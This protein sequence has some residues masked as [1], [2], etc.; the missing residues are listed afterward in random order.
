[1]HKVENCIKT[2]GR[3]FKC[4]FVFPNSISQR[5]TF[6]KALDI[7]GESTLPSELYLSWN[8]FIKEHIEKNENNG[9]KEVDNT[10]RHLYAQYIVA[11]NA[12]KTLFASLIPTNC[13][14]KLF[15]S[16]L[17]SI[18][19]Q[20]QPFLYKSFVDAEL[21]DLHLLA[22]SYS[23]F[24]KENNLYES[25][26]SQLQFNESKSGNEKKYIII[27][28]ELIDDFWQY[29]QVLKNAEN[30]EFLHVENSNSEDAIL[31]EAED[32]RLELKYVMSQI[33][34]LLLKKVPLSDI[35]VSVVDI[36][37]LK[38][39][40]ISEAECRG[41]PVDFY[42]QSAIN[43]DRVCS[44][45]KGI[46]D[47][48][49]THYS[50]QAI[51]KLLLKR[52]IP[53]KFESEIDAF[54]TF[55]LKHNCSISWQDAGMWKNVWEEAF[56]SL[57]TRSTEE[58]GIGKLFALLKENIDAICT[59]CTFDEMAE[60]IEKFISDCVEVSNIKD[61]SSYFFSKCKEMINTLK[62][63]EKTFNKYLDE[64]SINRYDF[65]V[66][67]LEK[68]PLHSDGSGQGI[69]IFPYGAAASIPFK[70]HFVI[71]LNQRDATIIRGKLKFLRDDKR[72]AMS[73]RDVDLTTHFI[74]SYLGTENIQFS[75][76]K[77]TY[78]KYAIAHSFFGK[79]APLELA[80]GAYQD[81]YHEGDSLYKEECFYL[82]KLSLAKVS[83]AKGGVSKVSATELLKLGKIYKLQK[84]AMERSGHFE[85]Y[86]SF[87][88]LQES[89][90]TRIPKLN[91]AI[92]SIM[93]KGGDFAISQSDL[94]DFFLE[95][96]IYFLFKKILKIEEKSLS[97]STVEDKVM[98]RLEAGTLYH[99]IMERIYRKIF[100]F[101]EGK[102]C[103]SCL[104]CGTLDVMQKDS[105]SENI[106]NNDSNGNGY[107]DIAQ[108]VLAEIK[109]DRQYSPLTRVC[110]HSMHDQFV[111]AIEDIFS[112]DAE[113]FDGYEIYLLE[114]N[115]EFASS[116]GIL[117]KGK[118]D[119]AMK[120]ND[121]II[122]LDYKTGAKTPSCKIE[123]GKLKDFQMPLY[124]L[125]L[126]N[127]VIEQKD[128]K[129][130][131]NDSSKTDSKEEQN[132]QVQI[133]SKE[134]TE[135]M[136]TKSVKS[137]FFIKLLKGMQVCVF[138]D[139]KDKKNMNRQSF[140]TEI[141]L[142][143]ETAIEMRNCVENAD[144]APSQDIWKTC[145]EC[146]FRHICRT[147][148]FVRKRIA[149]K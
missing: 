97:F 29:E 55:G 148:F 81:G 76:S 14:T 74:Q 144:F 119:R 67:L 133:D 135:L 28:P 57:G 35:A 132:L 77:K 147:T 44:I 45:F 80:S 85:N 101:S 130:D 13:N 7:S 33:E 20:V 146:D 112:L 136:E 116:D 118:I 141:D 18:L 62:G 37:A 69:S 110:M 1:M 61:E 102:F 54:L 9:F 125:L 23:A 121:S 108:K 75:Y 86:H 109:T 106:S 128:A 68:E 149:G 94:H 30:I 129:T 138:E 122:L 92:E 21:K 25:S 93:M 100:V 2:N 105:S 41:I 143:K 42:V 59:A 4:C 113:Y 38:S 88:I 71:N 124:V 43:D 47:V 89:C 64:A 22:K 145:R 39:Y 6:Q 73:M 26:W 40:I 87:S 95:C 46:Q 70:H 117:Y 120:K 98:D 72:D 137:A 131:S 58:E 48:Y 19:P 51:K 104:S 91:H 140:E 114:G 115:L 11:C 78:K 27:Y 15:S 142:L 99:K 12:K 31:Y 63:V 53:W 66:S 24:L 16:W 84:E 5:I 103:K 60:C 107:K 90:T 36:E 32:T 83:S 10:L 139:V 126:E 17:S 79:V 3:N 123:N 96:P 34:D 56:K 111:R 134:K 8:M 52:A 65:F 82:E 50:Y 127:G 49:N